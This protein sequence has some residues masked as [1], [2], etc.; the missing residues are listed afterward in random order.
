MTDQT[1]QLAEHSDSII[2]ILNV[3][4]RIADGG[5]PNLDE[6]TIT[7]HAEARGYIRKGAGSARKW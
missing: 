6:A 3:L 4:R 5:R 1:L 2:D 7:R